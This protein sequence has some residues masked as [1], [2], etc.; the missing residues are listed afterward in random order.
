MMENIWVYL[1]KEI[2]GQGRLQNLRNLQCKLNS[3]VALFNEV[4]SHFV[5][6]LY[7]SITVNIVSTTL[8]SI[9]KSQIE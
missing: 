6:D 3:V 7:Q 9:Q 4:Q 5:T 2:Y 1:S 8:F